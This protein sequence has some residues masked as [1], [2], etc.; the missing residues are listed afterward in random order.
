MSFYD[1]AKSR[2]YAEEIIEYL[3]NV[4]DLPQSFYAKKPK[5]FPSKK[6][7]SAMVYNQE[8]QNLLKFFLEYITAN[9]PNESFEG[10]Y[11]FLYFSCL[12]LR[13]KMNRS[14]VEIIK[15]VTDDKKFQY[16]IHSY[17]IRNYTGRRFAVISIDCR[18]QMANSFEFPS[19]K[20]QRT[21]KT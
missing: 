12:W 8:L 14:E 18:R 4:V 6:L 9:N 17:L 10:L 2:M 5:D 15:N 7:S 13:S 19:A 20:R 1:V 11:N 3:V 21:G 16:G